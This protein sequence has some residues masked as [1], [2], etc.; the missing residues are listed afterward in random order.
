MLRTFSHHAEY[1]GAR[2]LSPI[3]EGQHICFLLLYFPVQ[4]KQVHSV[5]TAT[6]PYFHRPLTTVVLT[7]QQCPQ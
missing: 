3:G 6:L 5:F 7:G 4:L 2:T 1:N